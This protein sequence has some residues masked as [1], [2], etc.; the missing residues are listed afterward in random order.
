VN[1]GWTVLSGRSATSVTRSEARAVPSGPGVP[2]VPEA[3]SVTTW[4]LISVGALVGA[5]LLFLLVLLVM[6]RREEARAMAGFVPDCAVLLTRLAREPSVPRRRWLLLVLVGLYLAMPI[7]VV[8]DFLPV[9]GYL[10]DAVIV[11]LTFRWLLRTFGAERIEALW[12]GP[13]SSLRAVLKLAGA[14]E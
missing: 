8:P 7:D 3:M 9:V 4:L 12:P 14:R 11:L 2:A 10:D 6:G 5:Y 1:A 13:E